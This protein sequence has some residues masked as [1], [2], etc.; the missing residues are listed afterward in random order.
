MDEPPGS[1]AAPEPARWRRRKQR[2]PRRRDGQRAGRDRNRGAIDPEPRP[3]YHLVVVGGGTAGLAAIAAAVQIG[4]RVALVERRQ[5]QDNRTVA[6]ASSVSLIQAT[7][8]WASSTHHERGGFGGRRTAD[9]SNFTSVMTHARN[10]ELSLAVGADAARLCR[11]GVDIFLGE[12]RFI[13]ADAVEVN[14]QRLRFR[15]AL[16]ATGSRPTTPPIP[17]L[18]EINYLT[19]EH[20]L[21]LQTLPP[22]LAILG[23]NAEA[24]EMAQAFAALGSRVHLFTSAPRLL[25]HGDAIAAEAVTRAISRTGVQVIRKCSLVEIR[26]L[27]G[28]ASGSASGDVADQAPGRASIVSTDHPELPVDEILVVGKLTPN[29]E[30]LGLEAASIDY[31][32][33]GIE[34]D[35]RFR[36]SSRYVYAAGDVLSPAGLERAAEDEARRA[37]H[38]ALLPRFARSSPLAVPNAAF[39][40]PEVAWVGLNADDAKALGTKIETMTIPLRDHP[41]GDPRSTASDGARE[42]ENK[43]FL[44]LHLQR[45][46]GQILGGTLVASNATETIAPLAQ[47]V[48]HKMRLVTLAQTLVPYPAEGEVYRRAAMQWESARRR[49][50]RNLLELWLRLT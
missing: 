1:A 15:R 45:R 12:G 25:P 37:V 16:I 22:R 24:C 48:Q 43:G 50:P 13:A 27:I 40:Q 5:L 4:A 17:G 21:E 23:D 20:V 10:R 49:P 38:N 41:S 46:S 19:P 18:D 11:Q 6:A 28:S 26:P 32:L 36:T 33:T 47:A 44:C 2:R 29:V 30:R 8:A 3:V 35:H 34:V 39:T 9:A 42:E 31:D 7:R 14:N